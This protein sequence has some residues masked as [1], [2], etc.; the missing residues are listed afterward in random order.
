MYTT[1]ES[2]IPAANIAIFG[3]MCR[4]DTNPF[5]NFTESP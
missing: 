2:T 3:L 5:E 4:K 1:S